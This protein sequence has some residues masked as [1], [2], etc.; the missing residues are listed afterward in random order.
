VAGR[1]PGRSEAGDGV[2]VVKYE[3]RKAHNVF[4]YGN[5]VE[6][7]ET[8]SAPCDAQCTCSRC[9]PLPEEKP[10]QPY[11]SLYLKQKLGQEI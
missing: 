1:F 11:D 6:L 7:V 10:R 5:F 8:A 9:H 3:V 2:V 4:L